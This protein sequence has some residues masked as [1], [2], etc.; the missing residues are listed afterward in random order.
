MNVIYPRKVNIDNCKLYNNKCENCPFNKEKCDFNK[1]Y[2]IANEKDNSELIGVLN[3]IELKQY[4]YQQQIICTEDLN[5][6]C[7]FHINIRKR[8]L[9]IYHICVQHNFRGKGYSKLLI[10]FLY[11]KY[12]MPIQAVCIADSSSNSFWS[13]ISTKIGEKKSRT[14]KQL[15]I[16]QY[17]CDTQESDKINLF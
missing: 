4:F 8:K 6:F 5:S 13:H 12:K 2:K 7:C 17:G 16:Y 15:N 10:D 14:G 3:P 11:N 9:T 1:I